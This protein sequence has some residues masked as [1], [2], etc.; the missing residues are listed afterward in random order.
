MLQSTG[1]V[2]LYNL[3][4]YKFVDLIK[5]TYCPPHEV[6]KVESDFLTLTMKNLDCRKYVPDFNSLSRL[7]PYLITPESKRIARF[8]GGLAPGIKGMVKASKPTTFRSAVDLSFSLTQD[9]VRQKSV[10]IETDG[11]W[12]R[13]DDRSQKSKKGKFGSGKNQQRSDER[14]ICK[15]CNIRHW[16]HCRSDQQAKPY[17]ICE[18]S[19]HKSLDSKDLKNVV[20]YG[21]SNKVHIRTNCPKL[22]KEGND[23]PGEEKKRNARAFQLTAREAVNDTNVITGFNVVLGLD[24][25]SHN[26]ARIACDKKLIEVKSPSGEMLTIHGDLHYCLPE[27]VSLLKTSKFLKSGCVIYMAQVTIDELK[28]RMED[29]PVISEYPDIFPEDLPG[30]PPE[31]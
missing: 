20:C 14:P 21:C 15:T 19:G 24:S 8:I 7:V 3:E 5:E 10:K 23:K 29:I 1:K 28:P 2:S 22:A 16:G 11:K 4:W 30:L 27:K 31:R 12:K 6:E 26:Q 25:L 13:E 17:G 18:K 9:E